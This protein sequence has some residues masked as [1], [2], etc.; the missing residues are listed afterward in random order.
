MSVY[1]A[2]ICACFLYHGNM[3]ANS[4]FEKEE[5][6]KSAHTYDGKIIVLFE[7]GIIKLHSPTQQQTTS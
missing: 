2:E 1:A 7:M 6:V 3:D 4:S 5:A